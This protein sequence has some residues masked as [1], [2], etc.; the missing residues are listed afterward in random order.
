M[1]YGDRYWML[2]L[3]GVPL[4]AALAVVAPLWYLANVLPFDAARGWSTTPD[5]WFAGGLASVLA[6][7]ALYLVVSGLRGRTRAVRRRLAI[8]GQP[9]AVPS[10]SV[11]VDP[12]AAPDVSQQPLVLL[13]RAPRAARMYSGCLMIPVGGMGILMG[14][15]FILFILAAILSG[16]SGWMANSPDMPQGFMVAAFLG[17]GVTGL[18]ILSSALPA[19]RGMRIGVVAN[20]EGITL[21]QRWG[22]IHAMAW[23]DVQLFEISVSDWKARSTAPRYVTLYS[24]RGAL[25]W[26][27][28]WYIG[29]PSQLLL[30]KPDGIRLGE[31]WARE[32]ELLDLIAARTELGPL[33]FS[34]RLG[35]TDESPR[36][37]AVQQ[38]RAGVVSFLYCGALVVLVPLAP[39]SAIGWLNASIVAVM[40]CLTI[41]SLFYAARALHDLLRPI[42]GDPTFAYAHH[43]PSAP[44]GP[45]TDA[46][47]LIWRRS[48]ARRPLPRTEQSHC[49]MSRCACSGAGLGGSSPRW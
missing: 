6:I 13:W 8:A 39:L 14:T 41:F 27:E 16:S 1:A 15:I 12:A 37:L 17:S 5:R 3:V 20:E 31:M 34:R 33:T 42:V 10:S 9:D 24:G 32:R 30:F 19:L 29:V 47:W 7:T 23:Q 22:R 28:D 46:R 38:L 48:V 21:I 26:R 45:E 49:S 2:K 44:T 36:R 35:A 4:A 25:H 18:W 40:C 11:E 43:V